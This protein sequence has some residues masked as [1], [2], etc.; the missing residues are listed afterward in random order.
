LAWLTL[1][2]QKV[3]L[4]EATERRMLGESLPPGLKLMA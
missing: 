4:D 2:A 1:V 3:E